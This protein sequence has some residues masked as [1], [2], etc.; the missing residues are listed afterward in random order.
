MN[1]TDL[2]TAPDLDLIAAQARQE[3]IKYFGRVI[4]L[5]AP[6]YLSNECENCCTYCGFNAGR[7]IK[8]I[9]LNVEQAV[10][11]ARVLRKAGFRHILVLT[12]EARQSV[13][14]SYLEQIIKRLKTIFVS[15][16]LEVYPLATEEYRTLIQAGVDG[17]T[18]YQETYDRQ[19]YNRV[20]RF[21]PKK[22]YE[23]RLKTAERAAAAGMR[24]IGLGVLLGLHD[25]RDE[26]PALADHL[27]YLLKKYWRTQFQLSFPRINPVEAGFKV[28]YPV[29]DRELL[30]LIISFRLLFPQV[31][32]VLSTREPAR[33]RDKIFSF[34]ITQMSAG[35]K[36]SPGGYA[37]KTG[38]GEQFN[39]AD[40]RG[41]PAVVAA[42][43]KAGYE[44]IFK[45]WESVLK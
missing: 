8:R 2:L 37:L 42:I 45:D 38:G 6:L 11:E 23:W 22:N 4:Q 13:P 19:T 10:A 27:N 33:L 43:K 21:G 18:I 26:A 41:V 31:G 5:Y 40:G 1:I 44:P 7:R 28:P 14:V 9:T 16:S 39:I 35:S 30:H 15:I 20:H 17:L 3:T 25:W 34:G 29:S 12:G 32:F 24:R 36:T